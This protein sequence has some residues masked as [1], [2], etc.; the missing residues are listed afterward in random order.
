MKKMIN[1][2]IFSA[3]ILSSC[4]KDDENGVNYPKEL[5]AT[6][7]VKD[8]KVIV[9]GKE[10]SSTGY[11]PEDIFTRDLLSKDMYYISFQD[12]DDL[13]MIIKSESEETF[14]CTYAFKGDSL[15]L[16]SGSFEEGSLFLGN[17][18]RNYLKKECSAFKIYSYKKLGGKI[19]D[20]NADGI[21]DEKDK[22]TVLDKDDKYLTPTEALAKV[23]YR[24]LTELDAQDI[25]IVYNYNLIFK[26]DKDGDRQITDADN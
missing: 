20:L 21:V 2:L 6:V 15:F 18:N 19:V 25:V 14:N 13:N 7:E 22:I 3:I 5:V 23:G 26:V 1:L 10:V 4:S 24:S 17:G 12:I 11:K 8:F 9:G 16:S